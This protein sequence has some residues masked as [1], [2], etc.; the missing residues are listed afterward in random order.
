M[1]L[2]CG[3]NEP[4]SDH[5]ALHVEPWAHTHSKTL[6]TIHREPRWLELQL[7]SLGVNQKCSESQHFMSCKKFSGNIFKNLLNRK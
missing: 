1:A 7:A 4:L 6:V 3:Q 2:E 5:T